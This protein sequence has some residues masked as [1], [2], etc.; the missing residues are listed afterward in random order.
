MTYDGEI[1]DINCENNHLDFL[2]KFSDT[3]YDD[4]DDFDVSECAVKE[5]INGT[6]VR[7]GES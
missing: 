2:E 7:G 5:F 4:L 3:E 6:D 1:K